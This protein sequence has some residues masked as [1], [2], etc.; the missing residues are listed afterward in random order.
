[1]AD[2]NTITE[3]GANVADLSTQLFNTLGSQEAPTTPDYGKSPAQKIMEQM[4]QTEARAQAQG[5]VS[6]EDFMTGW[7]GVTTEDLPPEKY[8][9]LKR[10]FEAIKNTVADLLALGLN[11]A[12]K[13]G[14][15]PAQIAEDIRQG[16]ELK[17]LGKDLKAEE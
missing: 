2:V 8:E 11:M 15:H 12:E 14:I 4:A 6:Q 7:F 17:K 1:M 16:R 3:G 9:G 13:V 5:P 10:G